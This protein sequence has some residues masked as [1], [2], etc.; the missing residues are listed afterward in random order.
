VRSR[1]ENV[2]Y[3]IRILLNYQE[4]SNMGR[5]IYGK[6]VAINELRDGI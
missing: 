6:E 3:A 5:E 4:K 2:P 1:G